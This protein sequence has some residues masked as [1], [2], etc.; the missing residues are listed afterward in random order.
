[1]RRGPASFVG[2]FSRVDRRPFER[3]AQQIHTVASRMALAD[4]CIY[5]REHLLES[6]ETVL[7]DLESL[8]TEGL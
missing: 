2:L 1:M 4:Q 3:S 6:E 7:L 5:S 8:R